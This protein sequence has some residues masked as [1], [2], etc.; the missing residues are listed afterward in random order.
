MET[1]KTNMTNMIAKVR[2]PYTRTKARTVTKPYEKK[3]LFNVYGYK[4]N[5][6]IVVKGI[7]SKPT[8]NKVI[9]KIKNDGFAYARITNP[10]GMVIKNYIF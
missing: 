8:L 2:K 5:E 6:K 3:N 10:K 7:K 1:T 4:E 9:E